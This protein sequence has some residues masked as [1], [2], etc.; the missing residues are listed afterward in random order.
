[1]EHNL[2][3]IRP[4][5][6]FAILVEL[7][8]G[9]PR[10]NE[11][12]IGTNLKFFYATSPTGDE[13]I[14]ASWKNAFGKTPGKGKEGAIEVELPF[15]YP[16]DVYLDPAMKLWQGGRIVQF[17]T[18]RKIYRKYDGKTY[19]PVDEPCLRDRGVQCQCKP[20]GALLFK[21]PGWDEVG[22]VK[23]WVGGYQDNANVIDCLE[24]CAQISEQALGEVDVRGI[25]LLLYRSP[26]HNPYT[27]KK[28]NWAIHLEPT[29]VFLDSVAH[30]I[31]G[32]GVSLLEKVEQQQKQ[33]QLEDSETK[34]QLEDSQGD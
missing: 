10:P 30:I 2:D 15:R 5:M 16:E 34:K 33:Q 23:L 17:C 20:R 3:L 13:E 32:K 22:L 14:V 28:D 26:V 7:Q 27:G 21:V 11:N 29:R 18:G 9:S 19:V 31:S 8:K 4:Q 24:W 6:K 12:S 25:P 1:M